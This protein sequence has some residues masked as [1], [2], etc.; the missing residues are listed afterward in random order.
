MIVR[1]R[2]S[3]PANVTVNKHRDGRYVVNTFVPAGEARRQYRQRFGTR[4]AA[5]AHAEA[6][7]ARLRAGLAPFES[8]TERRP[9]MTVLDVL[10]AY[11]KNGRGDQHVDAIRKTALAGKAAEGFELADLE[12][13]IVER[14]GLKTC[15]KDFSFIAR[16]CRYAKAKGLIASHYFEKLAGDKATRRRLMPTG[17]LTE[18]AGKEIPDADL[19]LI[20]SKL[21]KDARRAVLFARTT[22]CRKNEVA[23]LDWQ[24]HWSPQGFRPIT[25][26]GSSSRIV[27]CDPALV[28]DPRLGRGLVFS[29]LGSTSEEIYA[30]LTAAWRYAVKAAKVPHYRFH[31]LRHTYGTRL[32]RDGKSYSDIACIMGITEAMAHV[33]A[34]EDVERIQQEAI[35]S[36][37]NLAIIA[38]AK[39]A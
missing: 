29:E 35:Q 14:K 27:A 8:E 34:H 19:E 30:K 22:G 9:A 7:R 3:R 37:N 24:A 18:S 10:V 16:S 38:M 20:V 31:D 32:R 33:Y 36:S 26:K 23:S 15:A 17:K 13:Y 6:I 2:A 39:L 5:A 1:A 25:Q 12:G 21:A 4:A 11:P 28:G